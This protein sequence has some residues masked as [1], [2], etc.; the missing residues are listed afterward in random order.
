VFTHLEIIVLT[1]TQTNK[2]THKQTDPGENIQRS[3]LCYNV[4]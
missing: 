1:D 3:L 2:P 4:G